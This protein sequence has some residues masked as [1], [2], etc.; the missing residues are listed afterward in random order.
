MKNKKYF[1]R[2]IAGVLV[3]SVLLPSCSSPYFYDGMDIVSINQFTPEDRNSIAVPI[4]L[5]LN[6]QDLKLLDFLNKL[7]TDMIDNP[8]IAK[9]LSDD[10][11]VVSK[12]YGVQD[13]NINFDD[14]IWSIF[15]ALGD[16]ELH[17]AAVSQDIPLFLSL[18]EERGLI[19]EVKKSDITKYINESV[20]QN[21][22]IRAASGVM[23]VG[24]VVF[25]VAA[26]G[27]AVVGA[28]AAA[29]YDTYTFWSGAETRSASMKQRAPQAYQL[30]VLKND[31]ENT[32]IMLSEYQ[33]KII[34]DCIEALYK[35]YPDE[36]KELDIVK[37]RQLIALNMPH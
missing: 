20:Y 37:L 4:N 15:K 11:Q 10:P 23:A 30:W 27:N 35:Y 7:S 29:I 25:V 6:S 32:H 5:T 14:E 21:E 9:Q 31:K 33:E 1:K 24:V 22:E 34:N 13:L 3:P 17:K 16:E 2:I 26:G 8:L 19:A 12:A 36:A 18:C 28:T